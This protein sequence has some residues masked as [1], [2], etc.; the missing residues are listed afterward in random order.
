MSPRIRW[1]LDNLLSPILDEDN[2]LGMIEHAD[3]GVN[4]VS[5]VVNKLLLVVVDSHLHWNF[6]WR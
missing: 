1:N 3:V 6:A 4:S 2:L 5:V